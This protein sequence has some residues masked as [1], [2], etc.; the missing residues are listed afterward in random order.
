M[1]EFLELFLRN[2]FLLMKDV[3]TL[4]IDAILRVGA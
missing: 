4:V 2:A 1:L 3:A